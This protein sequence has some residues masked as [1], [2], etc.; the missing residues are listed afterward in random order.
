LAGLEAHLLALLPESQARIES[1]VAVLHGVIDV[2]D[3]GQ[4][5]AAGAK[6]AKALAALGVGYP[7]PSWRAAWSLIGVRTVEALEAL[8][9]ELG[10]LT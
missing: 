10:T 3:A 6:G 2:R 4:H 9:E 1:A 7:P 8:R 5:G